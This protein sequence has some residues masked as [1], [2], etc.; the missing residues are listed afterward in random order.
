MFENGPLRIFCSDKF[1]EDWASEIHVGARL[2]PYFSVE[3]KT[4]QPKSLCINHDLGGSVSIVRKQTKEE[5]YLLFLFTSDEDGHILCLFDLNIDGIWDVKESSTLKKKY[6]FVE[7][8]WLEVDKIE[9][10]NS[11]KPTAIKGSQHYQFKKTWKLD[12]E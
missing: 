5:S 9:G 10:R 4:N 1:P 8:H 3:G 12:Q 11:D 6:I 2:F 7:N